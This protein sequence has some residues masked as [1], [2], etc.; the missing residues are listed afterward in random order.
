M[1]DEQEFG[2]SPTIKKVKKEV[3]PL[4]E[5]TPKTAAE[6]PNIKGVSSPDPNKVEEEFIY[7]Y[8][9]NLSKVLTQM[10]YNTFSNPLTG[11]MTGYS[12][13]SEI[14]PLLPMQFS[15]QNMLKQERVPS[16]NDLCH[17]DSQYQPQSYYNAGPMPNPIYNYLTENFLSNNKPGLM[18]E[19]A[20]HEEPDFIGEI[21]DNGLNEAN[22]MDKGR[23]PENSWNNFSSEFKEEGPGPLIDQWFSFDL[24]KEVSN[25]GFLGFPAFSN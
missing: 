13:F 3:S 23:L 5:L 19:G 16:Y 11:S 17:L 22:H 4:Y 1:S 21:K 6:T 2:I 8:N 25:S 18:N 12:N 15:N 14:Q 20:A 24:Q 9:R 7:H 10:S